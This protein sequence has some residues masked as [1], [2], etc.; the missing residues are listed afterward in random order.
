MSLSYL[1]RYRPSRPTNHFTNQ[2]T[3]FAAA[4]RRQ[5]QGQREEVLEAGGLH[6]AGD[7]HNDLVQQ[8]HSAGLAPAEVQGGA[9]L[10]VFGV[11]L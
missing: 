9:D 4:L 11:V 10:M 3:L 7:P 8:P 5:G 2:P 6:L 1:R